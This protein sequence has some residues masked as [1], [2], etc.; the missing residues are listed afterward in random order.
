MS[1]M[2]EVRTRFEIGFES[3]VDLYDGPPSLWNAGWQQDDGFGEPSYK[4]HKRAFILRPPAADSRPNTANLI[5]I[6]NLGR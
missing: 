3:T 1:L 4:S 5:D 2:A 6:R